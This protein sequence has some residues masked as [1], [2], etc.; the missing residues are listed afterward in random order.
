[1]CFFLIGH[2]TYTDDGNAFLIE[3]GKMVNSLNNYFGK[4]KVV[5]DY[6]FGS[7]TFHYEIFVRFEN[8]QKLFKFKNM[9]KLFNFKKSGQ[10]LAKKHL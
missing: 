8:M 10:S 5:L 6:L 3:N 7:N 4:Q 1:M 2:T 9:Q